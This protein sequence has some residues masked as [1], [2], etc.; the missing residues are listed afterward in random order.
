MSLC[1][2]CA[3]VLNIVKK[4]QTYANFKIERKAKEIKKKL[5]SIGL[6]YLHSFQL[7]IRRA[8]VRAP[9]GAPE[10]SRE[11]AGRNFIVIKRKNTL[12]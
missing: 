10:K 5:E 3:Q 9:P 6:S 2:K 11:A 12:P 1:L 8:G 4:T 7:R